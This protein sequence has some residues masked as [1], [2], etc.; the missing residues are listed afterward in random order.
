MHI[1]SVCCLNNDQLTQ[2][3]HIQYLISFC[4]ICRRTLRCG[5]ICVFMDERKSNVQISQNEYFIDVRSIRISSQSR[6]ETKMLVGFDERAKQNKKKLTHN[7]NV[8]FSFFRFL[9]FFTSSAR[10]QDDLKANAAELMYLYVKW[11]I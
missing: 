1:E 7:R 10:N 2:A 5:P 6:T 8:N 9:F 4:F 11:T 3:A